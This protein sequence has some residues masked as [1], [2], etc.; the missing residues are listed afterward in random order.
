MR[1]TAANALDAKRKKRVW[2]IINKK[3]GRTAF[4]FFR[5]I[6]LPASRFVRDR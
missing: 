3:G 1:S 2:T 4:N 5:N 6:H